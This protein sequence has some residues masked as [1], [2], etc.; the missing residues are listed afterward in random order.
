MLQGTES[1]QAGSLYC[2]CWLFHTTIAKVV[3]LWQPPPAPDTDSPFHRQGTL[4]LLL[5]VTEFRS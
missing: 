5:R 2:H 4:R 3:A 1:I